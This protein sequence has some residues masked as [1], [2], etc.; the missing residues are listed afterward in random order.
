MGSALVGGGMLIDKGEDLRGHS[1]ALGSSALVTAAMGHRF[2][3]T[4]AVMPAG[5]VMAA[6]GLSTAYHAKKA[7]E[8]TQ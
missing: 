2:V 6:G 5:I 4:R 8:W 3:T 7:Y 1:V